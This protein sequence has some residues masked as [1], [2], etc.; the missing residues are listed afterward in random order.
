MTT[1]RERVLQALNHRQPD[2]VPVDLGGH[3]SSGMMAIAYARLK[4]AMGIT[5]GDIYVYDMVQQLAIIESPILD[6]FGIDTIELGRGFDLFPADWRAWAL[7]DGTPCKIPA[8]IEPH[9]MPDG[10]WGIYHADG[11]LIG[12][13]K[14]GCLYFEQTCFPLLDYQG[15]TFGDLPAQLEKVIWSALRTPPTR[16]SP[17]VLREGARAL[18]SST[19]RAIIGLF[20]G[21]LLEMGEFLFRNDGFL[22][23]L[24]AEPQRAHRFLDAV[25]EM[26]LANL[27]SYLEAVGPYIDIISFGDDLGMQTGPMLSPMMYREFFF[28]RH[29]LL[30][31][32]AKQLADVKVMLHCCGGIYP[33]IPMLIEA[34]LDAV[35]PVQTTCQ[36]M[37]P[38]RLKRE[39]GRDLT[40]WGGGC[41]TRDVLPHGIPSEVTADV[42][43]RVEILAPGGGFV[44]QQIHNIMADV[45]PENVIAML[46]AINA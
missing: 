9:R 15:D 46:R 21:N 38:I 22:Y 25:V 7:P 35:N 10:G 31:Q 4:Q 40:F 45:P 6:A 33:L 41:D 19:D 37:D 43:R 5:S 32:T 44:F 1:S 26:H 23:L 34:G 16:S 36:D 27:Q 29:R 30:W 42:R 28:P 18:R 11:T 2:R 39:F 3:R 24:A 14:P 17:A 13:Q 8:F 20:G 12:I